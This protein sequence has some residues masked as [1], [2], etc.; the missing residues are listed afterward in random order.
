M[1]LL[2]NYLLNLYIYI[3]CIIRLHISWFTQGD[4][5]ERLNTVFRWWHQHF[6][7]KIHSSALKGRSVGPR[8]PISSPK[9]PC[10]QGGAALTVPWCAGKCTAPA[11]KAPGKPYQNK[12][13]RTLLPSFLS[14]SLPPNL[15]FTRNVFVINSMRGKKSLYSKN[16]NKCLYLTTPYRDSWNKAVMISVTVAT[17]NAYHKSQ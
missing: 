2:T 12:Q 9:P 1:P 4:N 7:S 8:A 14:S 16:N 11:A 15:M 5:G 17:A 13:K 10:R 6:N 3:I